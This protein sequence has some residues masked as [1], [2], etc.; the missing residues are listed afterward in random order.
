MNRGVW[1]LLIGVFVVGVAVVLVVSRPR[2]DDAAFASLMNRAKG[3]IENRE[4]DNAI[5]VLEKVLSARPD[6]PAA[7]RNMARAHQVR[8]RLASYETAIGYLE[9]AIAIEPES[10][11]GHY[12]M[13]LALANSEQF[14]ASVPYFERA[15]ELDPD[16][17]ALRYQLARAYD[18]TGQHEKKREQLQATIRLEPLH[19]NAV[20]ALGSDARRRKDRDDAKKFTERHKYLKSLFGTQPADIFKRCVHTQPETGLPDGGGVEG[21]GIDTPAISVTWTDATDEVFTSEADRAG[22]TAAVLEVDAEGRPV[23]FV[24]R[25]VGA[26]DLVSMNDGG[27]FVS[28]R[29]FD[30]ADKQHFTSCAVGDFYVFIPEGTK[31][32]APRRE[33]R[34]DVLLMHD[35]GI[36]L[37]ERS[38][39]V[40]VERTESSGLG[41]VRGRRARWVDYDH[42]CVLDLLVAGDDGLQL[43]ENNSYVV[44]IQTTVEPGKDAKER[45]LGFVNVTGDVGITAM[46][47]VSDVAFLE[48]DGNVALDVVAVGAGG[49]L[50]FMNQRAGQFRVMP[51]PPGPWP[52]ARRV[53]VNDLDNDGRT[54][55]VLVGGEGLQVVY[56]G[57]ERVTIAMAGVIG[58]SLFDYDNDGW[59]DLLTYDESGVVKTLRNTGSRDWKA[60]EAEAIWSGPVVR[61]VV[62]GDFDN[63]GDT[64]VL[65]VSGEDGLHFLRNNGGNANRQLKLRLLT[66]LTNPTGIGDHVELRDGPLLISRFVTGLPVEIG[67]GRSKQFD[68]IQALWTNGVVDNE[69]L[70]S[71]TDHPLEF[72]E[73]LVEV[74]SCPFLFAWNGERYRFVTDILGNSP[75]GLSIARGQVLPSDPDE[76]VFVGTADELVADDGEYRLE[77]AE[78]YREVLYLDEAA[79]VAVD[80]AGDVEIHPTDKLMPAPFPT[81]ELWAVANFRAPVT[82]ES[83]D[84]LDRTGDVA[85]L[86]GVFAEPGEV[87]PPPFRGLCHPMSLVMDF[88]SLD[89][90]RDLVLVMTGWLRYG[91]ASVNIAIEQNPAI[92]V[93]PPTLEAEVGEGVWKRVD[94]VV[95]MPAGKTKT[96]LVDLVGRLPVGTRRLRLTSTFEIRWDRIAMGERAELDESAITMV[97]PSRAEMYFRGFPEMGSRAMRHPITPDYEEL[98]DLPAWRTTPEGFCTRFGDVLELVDRAD[99]RIAILNGG[100]AVSLAY[101]VSGFPPLGDGMTRSFFFYSVGW[102]KDADHNV[103][104]GDTVEPLP[105]GILD[106]DGSVMPWHRR[107]NTRWVPRRAFDPVR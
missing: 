98:S 37:L 101:P 32:T 16:T 39:D 88:G 78:C 73:R 68:T 5:K 102:E 6:S 93:I 82:V 51:S 92:E 11:A 90:D 79:L 106:D 15:V 1:T 69:F 80:H 13:G 71:V 91:S 50:V 86:D 83:S 29:V 43:W 81:S 85:K 18:T 26:G 33:A 107:Y 9:R 103:V 45:R 100:D 65:V 27:S 89:V 99:E 42:N 40:F 14:E 52:A 7:L 24:A 104:D 75:L 62:T 95:G 58:V 87:L 31:K 53:E 17:A 57:G 8:T 34:N 36:S 49:S 66:I 54:D 10:V 25:P 3:H 55:A 28:T 12:L 22:S 77:V 84:G 76:L 70:V 56:G 96:I 44:R 97:T 2:M 23:L 46:G 35:D 20:H 4:S 48:M 74:G 105:V 30:D 67:V 63:D 41:E 72:V 47:P 64:D 38:G 59:L 60:G 21:V 94:V 19:I 61:E